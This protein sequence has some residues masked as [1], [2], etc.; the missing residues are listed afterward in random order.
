[1]LELGDFDF[2][3]FGVADGDHAQAEA[4]AAAAAERERRLDDD[5]LSCQSG[6]PQGFGPA[7]VDPASFYFG[8][9]GGG[10]GSEY[11]A[12]PNACPTM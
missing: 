1:M 6:G 4:D 2:A 3:K 12:D 8:A 11:A 10:L 7:G 5:D 9:G